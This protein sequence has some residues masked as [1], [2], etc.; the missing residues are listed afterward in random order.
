[1]SFFNFFNKK[2]K[3][4]N[5]ISKNKI[6]NDLDIDKIKML[7]AGE[8][9]YISTKYVADVIL[10]KDSNLSLLTASSQNSFINQK[11]ECYKWHDRKGNILQTSDIIEQFN[12][13]RKFWKNDSMT[14]LVNKGFND[15][16]QIPWFRNYN[17]FCFYG[18]NS[19]LDESPHFLFNGV[20]DFKIYRAGEIV[21]NIPLFQFHD[22]FLLLNKYFKKNN[23]IKSSATSMY[24]NSE[25]SFNKRKIQI[26]ESKEFFNDFYN[27]VQNLKSEYVNVEWKELFILEKTSIEFGINIED[28]SEIKSEYSS[29]VKFL[30]KIISESSDKNDAEMKFTELNKKIKDLVSSY[31][32]TKKDNKN[33]D[34]SNNEVDNNESV[35]KVEN[36]NVEIK[37]N[38]NMDVK[39]ILEMN[40]KS[41]CKI[42]F[43]FTEEWEHSHH[44]YKN[45]NSDWPDPNKLPLL[46]L[47]QYD[48]GE[49]GDGPLLNDNDEVVYDPTMDIIEDHYIFEQEWIYTS[50]SFITL[51]QKKIK[52]LID[53]GELSSESDEDEILEALEVRS[54]VDSIMEL[55]DSIGCDDYKIVE[56]KN[57]FDNMLWF[58]ASEIQ[59]EFCNFSIE[60]VN[61]SENEDDYSKDNE[62]PLNSDE[63]LSKV[64]IKKE[65]VKSNNISDLVDDLTKLNDLKEKGILTKSEFNEQK[66]KL[67]KQ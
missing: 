19:G 52:N 66:K 29:F 37:S 8:Y 24:F 11:I 18:Y 64:E 63:S 9:D 5:D 49:A 58:T 61:S 32:N 30:S 48:I 60:E 41:E 7:E 43:T 15:E 12:I 2:P 56:R 22:I 42:Y 54:N 39:N 20:M 33:I 26:E 28:S 62:M 6:H 67:L 53:S 40:P 17:D 38:K 44:Q 13:R 36:K 59:T 35:N 45:E 3:Q 50:K 57:D 51:A 23:E 25:E 46:N 21:Y 47:D 27:E 16:E 14:V 34:K 65:G 10:L 31:V 4:K 1:M 55:F